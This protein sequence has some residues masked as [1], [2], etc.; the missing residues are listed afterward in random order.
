M[1]RGAAWR[2][3]AIAGRGV[4]LCGVL[5]VVAIVQ[6]AQE[7][8]NSAVSAPQPVSKG[9]EERSAAPTTVDITPVARDEEIGRRLQSVLDATGWF[10]GAQV[11]VDAGVVF[12]SG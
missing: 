8:Q 4:A 6:G 3:L 9:N 5:A 2:R 11:R 1:M 7:A 10:T 12:L